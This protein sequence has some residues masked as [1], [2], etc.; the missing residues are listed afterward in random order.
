MKIT[1]CRLC[2]CAQIDT[3]IDLGYHPLADTFLPAEKLYGPEVSYPLQLG[4]CRACGHVSKL[5]SVSAV[6]R[7]QKQEYSYDSSNSRVAIA[8]FREFAVCVLA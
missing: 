1:H 7:Y 5:Y 2:D 3:V 4:A 8:H 6:D